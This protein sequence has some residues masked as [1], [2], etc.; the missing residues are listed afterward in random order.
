MNPVDLPMG[1]RLKAERLKPERRKGWIVD[2]LCL[3]D[4]RR[5]EGH[6]E[7]R[8]EWFQLLSFSVF[9]LFL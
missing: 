1:K 4:R 2:R 3:A 9:Q 5:A 8:G 7:W 6:R